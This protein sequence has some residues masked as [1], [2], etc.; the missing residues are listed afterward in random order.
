MYNTLCGKSDNMR[1]IISIIILC[2]ILF[3]C[4]GCKKET[5]QD[6]VRKVIT[7]I[8]KA[9]EDKEIRKIIVNISKTYNDPQDNN[10]ESVNGLL[11]AYFYRFPQISVYLS[12]LAVKVEDSSATATFK[13]FLTSRG[14]S[15]SAPRILPQSL[16]MYAFE[17]AL[18]KEKDE[19]KVVSAVWER[20]GD[21]NKP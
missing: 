5:E 15:E 1:T 6:R 21:E 14:A 9:A 11:I 12:N 4:L 3:C 13:A 17:V 20:I 19:W 8:Q 7:G 2:L 16:G 10:F 18:M